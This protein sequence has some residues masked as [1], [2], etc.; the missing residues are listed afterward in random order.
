MEVRSLQPAPP[1]KA[2]TSDSDVTTVLETADVSSHY[3][4]SSESD[5][6]WVLPAEDATPHAA[7]PEEEIYT[8]ID[9]TPRRSY[10]RSTRVSR[11]PVRYSP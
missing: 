10:R 3:S 11:K 8:E 6:D 1:P 4:D 5:C 9:E 7:R 2:P